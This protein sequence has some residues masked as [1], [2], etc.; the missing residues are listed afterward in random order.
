VWRGWLH[1]LSAYSAFLPSV[2]GR[3]SSRHGIVASDYGV[4][5]V[6]A[7]LRHAILDENGV[8]G[9]G[10]VN[11]LSGRHVAASWNGDNGGNRAC[12]KKKRQKMIGGVTAKTA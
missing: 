9:G 4:A 7:G 2:M 11:A 10:R 5:S 8:N 6:L 3:R 1:G 12:G